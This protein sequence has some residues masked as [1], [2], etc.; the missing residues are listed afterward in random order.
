MNFAIVRYILGW[1]LKFE[2]GFLLLPAIVGL[3]YGEVTDA[4]AYLGTALLCLA[5]SLLLSLKKPA[6]FQ[7]YTREGFAS[8]ALGWILLRMFG[9][10][11]F[12]FTRKYMFL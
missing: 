11:P 2:A 3:F 7:L 12:V 5:A 1:I 9:A 6:R 4:L 10:L 8:V